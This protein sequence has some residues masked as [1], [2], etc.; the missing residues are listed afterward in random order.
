[1]YLGEAILQ[2]ELL[3]SF[4]AFFRRSAAV[5]AVPVKPY[6]FSSWTTVRHSIKQEKLK[7][8]QREEKEMS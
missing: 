3:F 8:D 5:P 1:M 6:G 2:V 7:Q 4:E